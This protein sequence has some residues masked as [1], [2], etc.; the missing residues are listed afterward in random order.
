MPAVIVQS[1]EEVR[2]P[3]WVVGLQSFRRWADSDEFPEEGRIDYLKGEVWID[4]SKEQVFSHNQ[5][6]TEFT[7]VLASLVKA[8]KL[9]RYFTDGLRLSNVGADLSAVPDGMFI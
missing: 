8:E 7:A 2:L 6:K 5:C 1:D 3:E 4:M 9:G